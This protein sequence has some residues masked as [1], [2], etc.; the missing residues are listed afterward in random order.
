MRK[1]GR[2]KP[3]EGHEIL[4]QK[5]KA[6]GILSWEKRDGVKPSIRK[7]NENDRRIILND[8]LAQPWAPKSGKAIEVGCGTG[9]ILRSICKKGFTG[10]GI[11]I[12]K[13]AINMAKEQSKS[14]DIKFKQADICKLNV[15]GTG[16]F[17]LAIDG[18]CL[19]CILEP[20][21][22]RAFLRN[23]FKLLKKDGVFVVMSMCSPVDRKA[24][25]QAFKGQ[26]LIDHIIY[27]PFDK[28]EEFEGFHKIKGQCYLPTRKVPHWKNILSEIRQ[29]GFQTKLFRYA[30]PASQAPFGSLSIGA[31]K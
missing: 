20:K 31:L 26:K 3:Y 9:P 7:S 18:H 5:M 28:A 14:L 24:F 11:D 15:N 17:D 1:I 6:K 12:S 4:Y 21:D 13:T 16:K 23:I 22:R 8:I 10:L 25:L 29:A 19:H 2:K 27:V 30:E